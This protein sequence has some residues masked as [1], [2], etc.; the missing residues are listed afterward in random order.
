MNIYILQLPVDCSDD[1]TV[2]RL[3]QDWI[4]FIHYPDKLGSSTDN[5]TIANNCPTVIDRVCHISLQ[6]SRKEVGQWL[7]GR[8]L[9]SR[10]RGRR[11]EP[12]RNHC[13]VV[14]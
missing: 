2:A 6:A 9:D 10:P 1:D 5:G 11:F 7:S 3:P 4:A 13:I 14:L 12:H 8:V